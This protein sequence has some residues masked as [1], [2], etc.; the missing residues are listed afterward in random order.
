MTPSSRVVLQFNLMHFPG[1]T[2]VATSF[3]LYRGRV[4]PGKNDFPK[5]I[6]RGPAL[7]TVLV[8]LWP[9]ISSHPSSPICIFFRKNSTPLPIDSN[10]GRRCCLYFPLSKL[11]LHLSPGHEIRCPEGTHC[12]RGR[13]GSRNMSRGPGESTQGAR[14]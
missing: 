4:A 14:L 8:F 6:G 2:R 13:S 12:R 11:A 7:H 5:H 10:R 3:F 1:T 9:T